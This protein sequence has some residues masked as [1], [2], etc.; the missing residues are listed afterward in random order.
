MGSVCNVIKV[1]EALLLSRPPGRSD[2]LSASPSPADLVSCATSSRSATSQPPLLQNS[3]ERK[4]RNSMRSISQSSRRSSVSSE[5]NDIASRMSISV[6]L[7]DNEESSRSRRRHSR[8]ATQQQQYVAYRPTFTRQNLAPIYYHL[9]PPSYLCP[10]R[11]EPAYR[12]PISRRPN[13]PRVRYSD[14]ETYFVW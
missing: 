10:P 2:G 3:L 7:N 5:S 6:I 12:S 9:P 8:P 13:A 1:V 4:A 14:E 11:N